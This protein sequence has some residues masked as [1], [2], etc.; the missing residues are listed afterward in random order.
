MAACSSVFYLN[1][2]TSGME[3]LNGMERSNYRTEH[4]N[5]ACQFVAVNINIV[6]PK[7]ITSWM[8]HAKTQYPWFL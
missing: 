2:T 3:Q 8:C 4:L 5:I 7:D 6:A 1:R